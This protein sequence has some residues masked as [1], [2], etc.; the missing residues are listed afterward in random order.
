VG[1]AEL[2]ARLADGD[3]SLTVLA[4]SWDILRLA[5]DAG[6]DRI[7][8]AVPAPDSGAVIRGGDGDDEIIGGPK[9]DI[10]DGNAGDDTIRGGAG[11]DIV[12][13]GE[14][15]DQLLGENGNDSIES[16]GDDTVLDGG[17]GND[18]FDTS[19][20]EEPVC[21]AGDRDQVGITYDVAPGPL[22]G[23][24]CEEGFDFDPHPVSVGANT[25]TFR[26]QC[27]DAYGPCAATLVMR[28]RRKAV[29]RAYS[30]K[31]S[32]NHLVTLP[33]GRKLARALNRG[34]LLRMEI[35]GFH[36]ETD[37]GTD[38]VEV[39]EFWRVRVARRPR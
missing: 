1:A 19:A 22:F 21:G 35:R 29:R 31:G 15:A 39:D 30:G 14:G 27:N 8:A 32:G 24:D 28:F 20:S 17:A 7:D 5:G 38:E 2:S 36:H 3:D 23:A 16:D 4:G 12:E 10:L 25:I 37:E 33:V 34:V 18:Y 6:N 9:D 13:G 11:P 26:V